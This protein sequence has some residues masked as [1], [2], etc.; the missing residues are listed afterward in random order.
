MEDTATVK[1]RCAESAPRPLDPR[2]YGD[3]EAFCD[4]RHE[5]YVEPDARIGKVHRT[6]RATPRHGRESTEDN[7]VHDLD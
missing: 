2:Q 6:P 7:D 4:V 5:G 3:F 1:F